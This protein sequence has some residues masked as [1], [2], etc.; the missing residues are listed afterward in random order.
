MGR[1]N[2][3]NEDETMFHPTSRAR[4]T[5]RVQ[6]RRAAATACRQW[7]LLD[8]NEEEDSEVTP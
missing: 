6:E 2:R 7:W 5:V 4:R 3:Y 1:D 8:D